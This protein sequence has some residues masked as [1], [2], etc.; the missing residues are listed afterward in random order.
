MSITVK[1]QAKR[2]PNSANFNEIR[3]MMESLHTG[4][5]GATEHEV[6]YGP[7]SHSQSI[8]EKG[9]T[10]VNPTLDQND[11]SLVKPTQIDMISKLYR[12]R[13]LESVYKMTSS[14]RGIA[15]VVNM[16]K[17]ESTPTHSPEEKLVEREGSE[18]DAHGLIQLFTGL[19][20]ETEMLVDLTKA[21]L[22]SKLKK[23]SKYDFSMYDCFVLC[24]MSHG[25]KNFFYAHD[26]G[27]IEVS[28]ICKMFNNA[29]CETLCGKP[30]LFF[31]QACRGAVSDCGTTVKDGPSG[32]G[33]SE[34]EEPQHQKEKS[35]YTFNI[36]PHKGPT[37]AEHA[38]ILMAYSSVEGYSSYRNTESGSRF[39]RSLLDVFRQYA[40]M[41]D[42]ESMLTRVIKN[43]NRQG[44]LSSKQVP[45]PETTLTKKVFFWPG[46]KFD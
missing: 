28:S 27:K 36:K 5:P 40:C 8:T 23:I 13:L 6:H 16:N 39:I 3:N 41:E 33:P 37:T 29:N 14:P 9:L 45:K 35:K 12:P 44:D 32:S 42:V 19:D 10:I 22:L 17:F 11:S 21:D 15:V 4:S 46:M 1:N 18:V 30:K 31:I 38:D 34:N 20:F 2:E 25:K 7:A 43:V 24:I 26:G